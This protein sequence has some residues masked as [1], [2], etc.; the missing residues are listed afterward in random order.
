MG[1]KFG[2]G[3]MMDIKL[4]DTNNLFEYD[5]LVD[6]SNEGTIFHKTW[7]LDIFCN[8]DTNNFNVVYCGAFEGGSLVAAMPIPIHHKFGFKFVYLPKLTPYLGSIFISKSNIK[9][10]QKI[11]WNKKINIGFA[12]ILKESGLCLHY[13]FGHN[14]V[15]LQPFK[16]S[17]FITGIH[18]T[19][20]LTLDDLDK[21]WM[22][23]SR[24]R[25]NDIN[26]S[27][28][29][30]YN[31]KLG[32][33]DKFIELN[34]CTME[35]QNHQILNPKLWGNIFRTCNEKKCGQIFTAYLNDR[36]VATLFLVWDTKRSY[37]I[38]GGIAENIG[39]DRGVM[40]LLIWESIKYTKEVLN[41]N[42]FDFE[43]SDIK[44]I[45]SYFRKF[46]GNLNPIYFINDDSFGK[47]LALNLYSVF[48]KLAKR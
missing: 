40:S 6:V 38:G 21:V 11:S 30:N 3:G 17:K 44:S 25:R 16:W 46:G 10:D 8:T 35:R 2:I 23:F 26:K 39:N 1:L 32:D 48:S 20:V 5:A 13:S 12:K 18:Y 31:I 14:K 24:K 7:W 22:N 33:L 37:Y 19:Y 42:E 45:E 4:L 28:K 15:D 47:F 29:Q 41:L 36:A 27:C 9:L 43:G 34:N